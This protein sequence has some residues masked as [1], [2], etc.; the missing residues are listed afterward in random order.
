MRG[1]A[2]MN[3]CKDL[4]KSDVPLSE[5]I[6]LGSVQHPQSKNSW[7]SQD[8]E[9]KFTDTCA[10]LAAVAGVG[11]LQMTEEALRYMNVNPIT[12]FPILTVD[13]PPC[14]VC[15]KTGMELRESNH[16]IVMIMHMNDDHEWTRP[17]IAEF[18]KQVENQQVGQ[19][20]A[21]SQAEVCQTPVKV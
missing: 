11:L 12:A 14:I 16:L 5:A 7:G 9:G 17:Q 2:I 21:V 13:V 6:I 19:R 1:V 8:K 20:D 18:V 3:I 15:G 10:V 4:P